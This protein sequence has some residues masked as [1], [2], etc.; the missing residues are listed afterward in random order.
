MIKRAVGTFDVSIKPLANTDAL[1]G[2]MALDKIFQGDLTAVGH[3]EMLT[4]FT[5]C[6]DSAG[7]VAIER[8]AGKLHDRQ[9]T[10]IFQHNGIMA[11]GAQQLS[12]VVVPDSGTEGLTGIKGNFS[13]QM[14][15]G[16]HH[17]TFE[18]DLPEA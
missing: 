11:R 9:G 1:P 4:A 5:Q 12:I 8:I 10:F 18:Y 14:V 6:E 16:Q 17:Y 3:G 7:Y 13:V 2:R 15:D